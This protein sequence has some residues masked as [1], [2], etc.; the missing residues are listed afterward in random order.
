[1]KWKN[2]EMFVLG[3]VDVAYCSSKY[4]DARKVLVDVLSV[5]SLQV[6]I[7]FKYTVPHNLIIT[8]SYVYHNWFKK[9]K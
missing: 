3:K 7:E 8:G 9:L 6:W 5:E 2:R 1:M 4:W